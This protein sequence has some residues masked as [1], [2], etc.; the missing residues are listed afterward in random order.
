LS[1]S[2]RDLAGRHDD[3][4]PYH[5]RRPTGGMAN[6]EPVAFTLTVYLEE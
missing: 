6:A 2:Y 3:D 1:P 5:S 4:D